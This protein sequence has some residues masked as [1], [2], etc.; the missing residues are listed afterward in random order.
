M[1]TEV[2]DISPIIAKEMLK[3]NLG[4]RRISDAHVAFLSREMSNDNWM[5]D[6]QPIRLTAAGGILDGQHRLN[7]IILSGTIQKFLVVSG[8]D[9]ESFI[10]M[11]TGKNRNASDV[12]SIKGYKYSAGLSA[13]CRLII[14]LKNKRSAQNSA[15]KPSNSD[16]IRFYEENKNTSYCIE[17][18]VSLYDQF[19]K[20]LPASQ[21]A[22]FMFLFSEKS[23]TDSEMFWEKLCTG[24]GLESKSPIKHLRNKLLNDKLGRMMLPAQEKYALIILSWNAYRRGASIARLPHWRKGTKF[25]E[26][27]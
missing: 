21:I 10:V 6:A 4:N 3:R 18:A 5:F 20:V 17:K 12:M 15:N 27:I 24:L 9:E 13:A 7:A 23:V 2:R 22:A 14:I 8:V 26:I 19:N 1:K 16:I 25:P 11:D